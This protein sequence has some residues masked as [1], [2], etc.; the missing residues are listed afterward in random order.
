MARKTQKQ[1]RLEEVVKLFKR[2]YPDATCALNYKTPEQLL[3]AT[4]LSAQ[5]TDDRVNLVT[6][7]LFKKYKSTKA[8]AQA[9]QEELERDIHSTGFYRNKAKNIIHC[10]Q[11]LVRDHKGKVP[12]D[13][14]QL[15]L[16]AG[17]GRK[18]ANVVLGNAYRIAS[19]VVVDTHVTRLSNRLG[20]V[21]SKNAQIIERKLNSMVAKEDW[22]EF[23]HWMIEHGRGVCK[24]RKPQCE[25]CFLEE[26]CPKR[27]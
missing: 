4:I 8:F 3:I 2:Y 13:M 19:G 7:D 14:D 12:Q 21:K 10:C 6:K 27:L 1:Q 23:P 17:V 25:R 26:L 11:V 22:I 5:C 18:T 24:A 9:D 15:V 20:W 16:L